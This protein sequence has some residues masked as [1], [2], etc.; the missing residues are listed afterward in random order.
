MGDIGVTSRVRIAKSF[1]S[2]NQ[3]GH[4]GGHLENLETTSAPE[5]KSDRAETWW[6]ALGRHVDSEVKFFS[7]LHPRWPPWRPS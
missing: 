2:N 6:E 4:N 1:R 5:H 3:D 7:F